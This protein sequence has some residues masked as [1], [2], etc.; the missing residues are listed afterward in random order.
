MSSKSLGWEFDG[1]QKKIDEAGMTAEAKEK[2]LSELSKL[3]MM[4]PMSAEATVVRSYIDWMVAVP[5]KQ[6]TKVKMIWF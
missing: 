1:L 3:K 6:K 4:S 2:V 5:W